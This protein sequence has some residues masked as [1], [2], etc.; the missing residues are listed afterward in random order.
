[1]NKKEQNYLIIMI[2]FTMLITAISYSFIGIFIPTFKEIF[3]VSDKLIGIFLAI[4]QIS[5]L[6]AYILANKLNNKFGQKK[7]MLIGIALSGISVF[8]IGY[9]QTFMQVMIGYVFTT[10][11]LSFTLLSI[12]TT[13]PLILVS[14]QS[15]LFNM[16]HGFFGVGNTISQKIVGFLLNNNVEWRIIYKS[17]S[18][19]FLIAFLLYL[20]TY[21]T[22]KNISEKASENII[23]LKKELMLFIFAMGF[24]VA[25]EIQMGNWFMNLLK[26]NYTL[27]ALNATTYTTVFFGT[28][29]LG[30][31]I[32][33]IITE[34]FGYFRSIIY[35]LILSIIFHLIGMF[36]QANGLYIISIVG[37]FLSIIF[38]TSIALMGKI[39]KE[40]SSKAIST[41]STTTALFILFSGLLMANL[42]DLI[43][44]YLSFYTITICLVLSLIFYIKLNSKFVDYK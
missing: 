10:F 25:A 30:R 6:I 7:L 41:V 29:T 40:N 13:V 34:K 38:P 26:N 39:F 37:L 31:F 21:E 11:A 1:M 36:L 35:A 5:S 14:F 15:V 33:G 3:K 28:F 19:G 2:F 27:T 16:V 17:I 4:I 43:G 42:N 12:N 44:A 9:S 23:E 22:Q 8:L 24:Y 32:G 20:F 18:L